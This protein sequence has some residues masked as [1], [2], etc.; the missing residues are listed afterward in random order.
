MSA[1][2]LSQASSFNAGADMWVV[3][4]RKNSSHVSK[5]DWYLNFQLAKTSQHQAKNLPERIHQI[6]NQC[7]LKDYDFSADAQDCLMIASKHLV[8][9]NWILV[10]KDSEKFEDWVKIIFDKWRGLSYPSLRV[11]LPR[12]QDASRFETLWLAAG[13]TDQLSVVVD[14]GN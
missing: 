10:V 12:G 7:D 3:P 1:Q 11:F 2:L 13:G 4:E 8:P 6:L 9:A 5:L 14:S